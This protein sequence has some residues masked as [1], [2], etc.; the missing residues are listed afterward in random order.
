MT[1]ATLVRLIKFGIAGL[2][3]TGIHVFVAYLLIEARSFPP[4]AANGVAFG[5][6]T[7]TSYLLNTSWAFRHRISPRTMARFWIVSTAG[8]CGTMA[9]SAAAD[10]MGFHYFVGIA[11][12]VALVPPMTFALH[13]AWTYGK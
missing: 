1:K 5:A 12:V 13:S 6:A 11:L 7:V 9:I 8:L 2:L 4:V 3:A 10:A